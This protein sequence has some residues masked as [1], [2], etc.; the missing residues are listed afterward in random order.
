MKNQILNLGKPLEKTEL[1]Q[2]TGGK[3]YRCNTNPDCPYAPNGCC[4]GHGANCR[5]TDHNG[6]NW[7]SLVYIRG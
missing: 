1:K 5:V 3:V 4:V 2:I 7:C 6:S